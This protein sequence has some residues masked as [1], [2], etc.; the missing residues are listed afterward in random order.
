MKLSNTHRTRSA[1]L[2]IGIT[3]VLAV[4]LAISG[5]PASLAY[6]VTSIEKQ[7]EA[8]AI[9]QR[10][11]AL[12]TELNSVTAQ[13][14]Q[15]LK[16]HEAATAAM[17]S[18]Q[19]RI[20]ETETRIAELQVRLGNRAASMY[21]GGTIS[22]IDVLLGASSFDEFLNTW[23]MVAKISSSDAALVQESKDLRQTALDAQAAFEAEQKKAALALEESKNTKEQMESTRAGM[24]T[25]IANINVEVAEL[26]EEEALQA[27]AA[28]RAKEDEERRQ[29]S[30]NSNQSSITGT[31]QLGHPLP[32]ATMTSGFGYR[33]FDQS[34]HQGIDFAAGTGTP[35][36]AAESGT[37][38][39]AYPSGGGSG[40]IWLKI[41]HGNGLVTRYLHSSEIYV[42]VGD[43]VT[44]GQV[45]GAVGNTGNS[46]G[47]HL[48]FGVELNGSF[49]N[50]LS[51]L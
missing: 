40:G 36:Y 19:Q 16:D 37:V 9:T 20:E 12:Q 17:E 18:E 38:S 44:K 24:L 32:G 47:A 41:V 33:D 42:S 23:D 51:Y 25:E 50:P 5:N 34:F 29:Q 43:Q 26:Q 8:D 21:K 30:N 31:G 35:Y 45:I 49:V 46:S 4:L 7:A 13:Y 27:E 14:E 11:D 28:L 3:C 22:F 10:I 1:F 39:E 2:F 15:A 48:H 6:G